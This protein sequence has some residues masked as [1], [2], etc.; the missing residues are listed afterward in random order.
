MSIEIKSDIL[1]KEL[2]QGIVPLGV[3]KAYQYD[4]ALVEAARAAVNQGIDDVAEAGDTAKADVNALGDKI[5]TQMKHG[6]GY[7]FTAATTTAMTDTAKIYVYTGSESGYTNGNWYYYNGTAWVSGG[8]YN[9]TALETDKT[10]T[11]NGAAA[12]AKILGDRLG[13]PFYETVFET[14]YFSAMGNVSGNV[15]NEITIDRT[16]EYWAFIKLPCTPGTMYQVKI[17][18]APNANVDGYCFFTDSNFIILDRSQIGSVSTEDTIEKIVE[19]PSNSAYVYFNTYENVDNIEYGEIIEYGE[20]SIYDNLLKAKEI[21]DS[22]VDYLLTNI[23]VSFVSGLATTQNDD[24]YKIGKSIS[25]ATSS[26]WSYASINCFEGETYAVSIVRAPNFRRTYC[27]FTDGNGVI[28]KEVITGVT[29]GDK[30]THIVEVPKNATKMYVNSFETGNNVSFSKIEKATPTSISG[31]GGYTDIFTSKDFVAGSLDNTNVGDT[32]KINTSPD[33]WQHAAINCTPGKFYA[34]TV[35]R[36]PNPNVGCYCVFVNESLTVLDAYID[37]VSYEDVVEDFIVKA[38]TG[39]SRLYIKTYEYTTSTKRIAK[40][41]ELKLESISKKLNNLCRIVGEGFYTISSANIGTFSTGIA[42]FSQS[43]GLSPIGKEVTVDTSKSYWKYAVVDC[44]PQ[45]KYAISIERTSNIGIQYVLFADENDIIINAPIT[46]VMI[47]DV[48]EGYVDVPEKAVK[49]Y[50][51]CYALNYYPAR[52]H[53]V[54]IMSMH[55]KIQA[56]DVGGMPS[57]YVN[58]IKDKTTSIINNSGY[59][60]GCSFAFATDLH[61]PSNQLNSKYLIKYILDNSSVPFALLGGDY[62]GAYGSESDCKKNGDT[63][64]SY[65]GYIGENRVFTIRGNHDFTI[66]GSSDASDTSGYTAPFGVTYGYLLRRTEAYNKTIRNGRL[67]YYI[68]IP[69]SKTRIIMLDSTDTQAANTDEAWGVYFT[70]SQ[71]QINWLLNDALNIEDTNIIFISHVPAAPTL[72]SYHNSQDVIHEIAIALKNK[73]NLS[74]N[75]GTVTA[76]KD[77]TG[78]TNNFICHITGHS[79]HDES[80]VDDNVLSI[81]TTCDAAYSD[82]GHGTVRDTI[83]EQAFDTF[84]IDYDNNTIKAIRVGRG[85]DRSWTY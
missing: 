77:F 1:A 54:N 37:S 26:S 45:I 17:R 70:V 28:V 43:G 19:A 53:T 33:Y 41:Q 52:I 34:V 16:K 68:D 29:S 11:I 14:K 22:E 79:H 62:P 12:D 30:T 21:T 61:F 56:D 66:K 55:D 57:Y 6:Y 23:P 5:L 4:A 80:H 2:N 24:V 3:P 10:L 74:Y 31:N 9:A 48:F 71:P 81:T 85:N 69:A 78:T 83:T 65:M 38:P 60:N 84:C 35:K 42:G 75:N 18:R 47:G 32:L 40:I 82:D 63:L 39:A 51:N 49:M 13:K 46:G 67:Y 64:L 73:R 15:G 20:N 36:A 50:V 25:I 72:T 27:L 59:S 58:H 8:V 76:V 7:P 44:S